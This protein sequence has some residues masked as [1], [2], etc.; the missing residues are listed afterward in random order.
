MRLQRA[1]STDLDCI[2]DLHVGG[3]NDQ[4]RSQNIRKQISSDSVYI[5]IVKR[6]VVAY[7]ILNYSFY[8]N[9]WIE[10]LYVQQDFRCQGIGAS[11]IRHLASKCRVPKLFTSTNQSNM[12]M[13]RLLAAQ[14]FEPSGIIENLDE[15]D[16]ELVYYKKV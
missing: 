3:V 5:A 14:G 13:Q 2:L 15:G 10:M 6:K 7:A 9:G 12:S 4:L 8:D 11:L 1:N 16:P